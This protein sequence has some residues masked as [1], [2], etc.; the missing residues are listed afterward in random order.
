MYTFSLLILFKL[1]DGNTLSHRTD[2][3][4]YHHSIR[5]SKTKHLVNLPSIHCHLTLNIY[6]I[7]QKMLGLHETL[8]WEQTSDKAKAASV[9][10]TFFNNF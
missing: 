3:Q 9:L 7:P 4:L 10:F 2:D 5:Y 6:V 8:L 1:V